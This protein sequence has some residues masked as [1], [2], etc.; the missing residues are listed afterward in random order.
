MGH[1]VPIV[2]IFAIER[3]CNFQKNENTA[4]LHLKKKTKKT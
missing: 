1:C 4:L 2:L 3:E